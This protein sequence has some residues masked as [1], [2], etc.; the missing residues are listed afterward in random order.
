MT[1]RK[2]IQLF[3]IIASK[4]ACIKVKRIG[5]DSEGELYYGGSKMYN[6]QEYR[7]WLEIKDKD[8]VSVSS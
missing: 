3:D 1:Y 2:P 8:V 7:T 5:R 4:Y 6:G